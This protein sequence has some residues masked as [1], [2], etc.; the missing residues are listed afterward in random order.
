MQW[1]PGFRGLITL[2]VDRYHDVLLIE[3]TFTYLCAA[4]INIWEICSLFVC[5]IR[6]SQTK[7]I[8]SLNGVNRLVFVMGTQYVY[9]EV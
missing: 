5:F 7:A 9:C 2:S 3:R 1:P 4:Y 6:I 8:I